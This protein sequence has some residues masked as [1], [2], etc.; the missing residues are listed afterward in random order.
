MALSVQNSLQLLNY[1][2]L[3]IEKRIDYLNRTLNYLLQN[4]STYIPINKQIMEIY[5]TDYDETRTGYGQLSDVFST[6]AV[7]RNPADRDSRLRI[8]IGP[9]SEGGAGALGRDRQKYDIGWV[10]TLM[11]DGRRRV[12]AMW[13]Y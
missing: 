11:S 8:K 2:L 7:F 9:M 13:A 3:V 1:R 6:D 10:E 4:P 12:T 5:T